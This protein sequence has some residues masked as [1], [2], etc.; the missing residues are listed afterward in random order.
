MSVIMEEIP[1]VKQNPGEKPSPIL[2]SKPFFWDSIIFSI[3]STIFGLSVSGIIVDFSS[4]MNILWLVLAHWKI[5]LNTPTSTV[6]AIR[7]FLL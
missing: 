3:A 7:I 4:Q 1:E 5:M 2:E 6:T